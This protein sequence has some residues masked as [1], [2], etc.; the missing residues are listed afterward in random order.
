MNLSTALTL[1]L[2]LGL[3]HALDVDHVVAT[4]TMVRGD[5]NVTG[6]LRIGALWGLGHSAVIVVLGG[7]LV[8]SGMR[9]SAR[10]TLGAE[11][12]VCAMLV[13]LGALSLRSSSADERSAHEHSHEPSDAS[14]HARP[15]SGLRSVMVGAVH[16]LAG[17]GSTA[18][19]AAS[20]ARTTEEALAFLMLF[21]VGTTLTMAAVTL[22]LA[23]PLRWSARGA[24]ALQRRLIRGAGWLSVLVGGA[25]AVHLLRG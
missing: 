11:L 21:A 3:R 19:L 24:P 23:Q 17:S 14:A 25:L 10:W 18:V 8:A 1:G 12:I 4:A 22:A 9:F 13:V 6:A 20:S 2:T 7:A 5:G 16:G 15:R